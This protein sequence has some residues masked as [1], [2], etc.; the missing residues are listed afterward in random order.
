[1]V[2]VVKR[3]EASRATRG[4]NRDA[5]Y[6]GVCP[7]RVRN[8]QLQGSP[9]PRHRQSRTVHPPPPGLSGGSDVALA[10]RADDLLG[11]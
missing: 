8:V 4:P 3:Q 10:L 11:R 7:L 5:R 1:M 6:Q 2:S 9:Y